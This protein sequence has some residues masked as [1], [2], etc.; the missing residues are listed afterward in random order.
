MKRILQMQRTSPTIGRRRGG[1]TLVELLVV[2]TII[3]AIAA[4][5]IPAITYVLKVAS[6][7]AQ[8][9][10]LTAIESGID[11]YYTKHGDYPPDFSNW[12]I[13][14]RHYLK[15][16]PDI[17][18]SELT[19]LLRLCDDLPDGTQGNTT[20]NYVASQMNRAECVVWSLGGFSSDPQFPFT[21]NGGP[22]AVIDQS[23][24]R[25]DPANVEYNPTRNAPEIDFQPDRL[26]F[27]APNPAL[28][29]SFTNRFQSNDDSGNAGDTVDVFPSYRL[30]DGASP[31]VYFDSRTYVFN[32]G[33]SAA[34]AFNGFLRATS[35]SVTGFDGIRPVYS[36]NTG[37]VPPSSGTYGTIE[38]ALAGWQ[39]MNPNTYQLLAP[40]LDGFYGELIDSNPA[41]DPTRDLPVYWQISGNAVQ[42]NTGA[43]TPAQLFRSD[44]S[45]FDV[46]GFSGGLLQRSV[47]PCRDNMANFVSGTFE[48]EL[49]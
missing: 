15:I 10:E 17:S 30:K 29:K 37:L 38:A 41:N 23:G 26:S 6:R 43:S 16:Y 14:R 20:G 42:P 19:L 7:G 35:E 9:S 4:L 5:S 3:S 44:C 12:N 2:I 11:S 40:G 8:K 25:I 49:P 1:F 36:T 32:A 27:V 31:V 24:S 48:D 33:T 28:A 21:G 18:D 13:V 39:F 22:L 46:T 34:P 45:R 47:N